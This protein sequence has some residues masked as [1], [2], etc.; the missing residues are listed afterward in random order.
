MSYALLQRS[1]D[2]TIDRQALEDASV[3]APSVTRTDCARL[4][5]ELFGIVVEGLEQAEALALQAALRV[6]GLDT[7]LVAESELPVLA[8]P[9]RRMAVWFEPPLWWV[10]DA[11]EV[12]SRYG[13]EDFVFAAAGVIGD[14]VHRIKEARFEL[15]V[16]PAPYRLQWVLGTSS[17]LRFNGRPYVLREAGDWLRAL[18]E[19]R[20][21]LPAG[22]V[23]RGLARCDQTPWFLYPNERAFEE[24][25]IWH[26]YHLMKGE[27]KEE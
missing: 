23:N 1:L 7:E 13:E 9:I 5:R 19:V 27:P 12:V 4:H 26:F 15:F 17:V 2:Q 14:R 16:A 21:V 20:A 25:I 3:V 24:E 18:C 6:R 11:Y 22:R 10:T 8:V